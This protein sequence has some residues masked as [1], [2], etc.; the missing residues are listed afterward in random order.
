M[1]PD[2]IDAPPETPD[3]EEVPPVQPP[4]ALPPSWT[5][6]PPEA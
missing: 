3:P 2:P 5:D 6:D 4:P 1:D